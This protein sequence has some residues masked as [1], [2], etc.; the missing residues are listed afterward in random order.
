MFEG[1]TENGDIVCGS[2]I[3]GEWVYGGDAVIYDE[4]ACFIKNTYDDIEFRVLP[5]TVRQVEI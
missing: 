5:E 3:Q 1:R 2:L 4:D